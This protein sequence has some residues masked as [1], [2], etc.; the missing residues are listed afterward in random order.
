MGFEDFVYGGSAFVSGMLMAVFF[1]FVFLF[2]AVAIPVASYV[3]HSLG[4]YSIAKRRGLRHK[5]LAWLPF[6][7]AWLLGSISDQYQYVVKGK[8]KYR[9][10]WLLLL[11]ITAVAIYLGCVGTLVSSMLISDY[12]AAVV[13]H[14]LGG[15]LALSG[16]VITL[17]VLRYAAYY[18]LFRS[19][20]PSNGVLYLLLSILVPASLP[21]VVFFI[22]KKDLGMPPRKQPPVAEVIAQAPV[23]TPEETV[24]EI[25]EETTEE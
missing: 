11:N 12:I 5:W 14:T 3:L 17:G 18:S 1:F 7:E 19:C 2:V 10:R 9:R 23:E 25:A 16:V 6:G 24:E 20:Q 21:F 13:A 22:R 4:L 8:I 15:W